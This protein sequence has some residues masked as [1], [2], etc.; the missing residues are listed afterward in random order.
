MPVKNNLQLIGGLSPSRWHDFAGRKWSRKCLDR[1]GGQSSVGS[2][3]IDC[4]NLQNKSKGEN[5]E[6]VSE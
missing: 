2:R 4:D 5:G 3:G 6:V 1:P